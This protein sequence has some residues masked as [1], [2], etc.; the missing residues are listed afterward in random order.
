MFLPVALLLS[1]LF[2]SAPTVTVF[3]T[4]D[5]SGRPYPDVVVRSSG[6]RLRIDAFGRVFR[7]DGR[8]WSSERPVAE[9]DSGAVAFLALAEPG[10][11]VER[12][13]AEGRPAV[14]VGV[15][16][17]P[18]KARV[19]YRWDAA[20]LAAANLV[21]TD[22]SGFQFRRVSAEPAVLSPSDFEPPRV[23]V[24][25]PGNVGGAAGGAADTAA[26]ARLFSLTITDADQLAFEKAG[27]VG[28]YR[29]RTA[30]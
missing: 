29:R 15:P 17:G 7:F 19:E 8:T 23:V 10:P 25:P 12:S 27:G 28:R 11:A 22:G 30:R 5:F 3:R 26:V 24:P 1:A 14:V 9:E 2:P 20:G 18:K 21:F 13:D 16:A 6:E 4:R